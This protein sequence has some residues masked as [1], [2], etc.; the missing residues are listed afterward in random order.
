MKI[1]IVGASGFVGN[2]AIEV[3]HEQGN[4]IRPIVRS[5]ASI[6]SMTHKDLDNRIVNAFDQAELETAFK[7]CDVVIHSILGSPGLIRGT[8]A[9]TYKA[10]QKAGVKRIVYLSSM[11]VHRSAP[12]IGTTEASPLVEKQPFPAHPAK[13]YAEHKLMQLRKNGAVEVVIFRPGIVF[14]PRSRWVSELATQLS[15]GSAYFINEGKGI[16]NSVYIDNLI[17]GIQ[18]GLTAPQ[19]DGEAFFVGDREIVTWLDF[20][21]PFAEA[22]GVDPTQIP[23][24]EVPD[25]PHSWKQELSGSIFNSQF[26]QKLLASIPKDLKQ[27][28]KRKKQNQPALEIVKKV[29]EIKP[30]IKIEPVVTEMMAELQQSQYKLPFSKA[31]RILGY[32]PIVSFNEGCQRSLEW[33]SPIKTI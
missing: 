24:L 17:H 18:L 15:Q 28:L 21:R 10:A 11:V 2:R 25:F 29:A 23:S 26:V 7:G 33:L 5:A 8:A 27:K 6:E 1:G 19:A 32:A 20:Y 13:I 31:E 16:C 12:A 4:E 3:F 22:F 9:P 14:G 30:A